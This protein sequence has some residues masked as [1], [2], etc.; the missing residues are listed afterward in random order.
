MSSGVRVEERR[1]E[2]GKWR[3][4]E[5]KNG[6]TQRPDMAIWK[7]KEYWQNGKI[8]HYKENENSLQS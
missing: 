7:N 4:E 1:Q 2:Y 5:G 8:E 3:G 6:T